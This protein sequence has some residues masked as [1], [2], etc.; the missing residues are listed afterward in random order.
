MAATGAPRGGA[1]T[2]PRIPGAVRVHAVLLFVQVTF[3][4]WAVFGKYTLR[5]VPPLALADIRILGSVPL[6]FAA[7]LTFARTAPRR[8]DLPRLAL[9]GLL[10]VTANQLLYI[11]GLRHTT[12]TNAGILMPSTPVFTAALAA[13]MGVERIDRRKAIGIALAV[14]GALAMLDPRSLD[15]HDSTALGN[16]MILG[17]CLCYAAFVVL[18]RPLLERLPTLTL[19]AWVYLLGG[20]GVLVIAT[21]ALIATDWQSV[22]ALACWALLYIVL[23]PT[24]L[25]YLLVSWAIKRSSPS[26]VA[27]Y[28]TLQPL[29]AALLAALFLGEKAGLRDLIGFALI[30]LGLLIVNRA[31]GRSRDA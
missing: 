10:G 22:P 29:T 18:Q 12:A 7:S 14:A 5:Y 19:V 8:E 16:A 17:N 9:L 1:S 13:A 25:N 2:S 4:S 20:I 23:V 6:F 21:P 27:T 28:T 24:T 26:L 30:A 11:V 31:S 3:G 15:L